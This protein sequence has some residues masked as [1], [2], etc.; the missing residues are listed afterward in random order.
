VTWITPNS[1]RFFPGRAPSTE[2]SSFC[3]ILLTNEQ[4]RV[5]RGSI[6]IYPAQP[7]PLKHEHNPTQLMV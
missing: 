3:V 7:N 4:N 2:L 6:F 1:N 5:E